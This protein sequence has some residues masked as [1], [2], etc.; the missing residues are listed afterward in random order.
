VRE[1]YAHRDPSLA[2]E[3][4]D[5]LSRDMQDRDCPPEVRQL[6]RTLNRWRTQIA[7]WHDAQVSNGPTEAMN[8]LAKRIKRVAF[9][10]TNFRNWRIRVLLYAGRPDWSK[11]A[12][13]TP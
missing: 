6:G 7:A 13:V 12:T 9:G 2:L 5:Q 11:L 1:L 3:W 10:M 4:V 8:N